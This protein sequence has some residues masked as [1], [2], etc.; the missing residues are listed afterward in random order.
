MA[1]AAVPF[2]AGS[3]SFLPRLFA[4]SPS[5]SS[6]FRSTLASRS[7]ISSRSV[8]IA[9]LFAHRLAAATPLL[10]AISLSLPSLPSLLGD[11][12]ESILRAVPKKKTSHS[13]KRSRQMAG[14]ALKDVNSLCK[15][16]A[17]GRTKRMHHMCPYCLET[18]RDM[19]KKRL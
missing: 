12:W 7:L 8:R 4:L 17:C 16:P 13:K 10:P 1:V 19:M 9:S 3:T 15:C 14:K 2:R 18:I 6:P 5:M 11:I